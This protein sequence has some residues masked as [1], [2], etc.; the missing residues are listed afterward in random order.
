MLILM[1][2]VEEPFIPPFLHVWIDNLGNQI[3]TN[4]G[5]KIVFNAPYLGG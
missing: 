3:V 2:G 1:D 5:Q 4:T